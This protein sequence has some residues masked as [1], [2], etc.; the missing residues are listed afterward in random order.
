MDQIT[1]IISDNLTL[2]VTIGLLFTIFFI[3]MSVRNKRVDMEQRIERITR[4][5]GKSLK[6]NAE[7]VSVRRKSAPQRHAP[8]RQLSTR[9]AAA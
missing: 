8:A 4:Q 7:D 6:S 9:A 2:L 1:K 5:Q 3:F